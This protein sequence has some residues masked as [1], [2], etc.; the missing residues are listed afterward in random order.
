MHKT[1]SLL[2]NITQAL[3]ECF[4]IMEYPYCFIDIISKIKNK[5]KRKISIINNYLPE[6]QTIYV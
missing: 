5:N 6:E 1:V 4:M 3:E 2:K